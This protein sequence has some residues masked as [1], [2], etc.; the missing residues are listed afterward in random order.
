MYSSFHLLELIV[1]ALGEMKILQVGY[2]GKPKRQGQIR[3]RKYPARKWTRTIINLK[4][5]E[6]LTGYTRQFFLTTRLFMFLSVTHVVEWS[7]LTR[8][9]LQHALREL[10]YRLDYSNE[11]VQY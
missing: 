5:N 7:C 6:L 11:N 10:R 2:V 9:T 4:V 8:L 1:S 3:K